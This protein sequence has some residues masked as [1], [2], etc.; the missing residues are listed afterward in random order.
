MSQFFQGILGILIF[1]ACHILQEL[2]IHDHKSLLQAEI[3]WLADQ[4]SME[5]YVSKEPGC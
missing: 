5:N 3:F 2:T 4:A 1:F